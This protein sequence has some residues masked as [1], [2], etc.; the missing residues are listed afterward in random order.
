MLP[1]KKIKNPRRVK[2][3]KWIDDKDVPDPTDQK[4][5]KWDEIP[6]EVP[7]LSVQK[8]VDWDDS[9]DGKWVTPMKRNP[10][11]K[12]E[13]K[14]R[15]VPNPKYKGEWNAPEIDNP[16]YKYDPNLY[17]FNNGIFGIEVWQVKAGSIFDDILVTDSVPEAEAYAEDI[18]W[19]MEG[20]REHREELIGK[21]DEIEYIEDE[22][23][24]L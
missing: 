17:A 20:E 2:P 19:R 24:D 18:L 12:G 5:E 23:E 3:S 22:K 8:P 6:R 15:T 10:E 21:E 13:W 1:P 11:Y 16:K 4:P 9:V 14:Q 7:D